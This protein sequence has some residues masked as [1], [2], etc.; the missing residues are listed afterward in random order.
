M[1]K[2][3]PP[4]KPSLQLLV[5]GLISLPPALLY[6]AAGSESVGWIWGL[7]SLVVLGNLLAL[8]LF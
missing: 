4:T 7:L 5:F 6:L 8:T 3:T 1:S 2:R